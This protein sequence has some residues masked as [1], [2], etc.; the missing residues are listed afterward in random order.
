MNMPVDMVI[1]E[2][3]IP[4][5]P[6]HLRRCKDVDCPY[7]LAWMTPPRRSDEVLKLIFIFGERKAYRGSH[8]ELTVAWVLRRKKWEWT[9]EIITIRSTAVVWRFSGDCDHP[10]TWSE[11]AEAIQKVYYRR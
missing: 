5:A 7:A 9:N 1:E 11:F 2:F 8:F 3:Q 10:P 4:K 6:L